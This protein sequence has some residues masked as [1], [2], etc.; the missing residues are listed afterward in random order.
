MRL[1]LGCGRDYRE[2]WVNV[3]GNRTVKLDCLCEFADGL[4]FATSSVE[5]ML[6][7]NVLEHVPRPALI[8]FLEEMHRV[9]KPGASI[10]IFVPHYSGMWAFKHITHYGFF[11]VGSFDPFKVEAPFNGERYSDIRFH[12]RTEEL[13]FFHHNLQTLPIL[14]K[15]PINGLFNFSTT[16]KQ[17]ME[18]FQVFGFDEIHFVLEVVK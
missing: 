13:L 11:G 3:D 4:P 10:E 15:L 18:R 1:H 6:L 5:A 16:W 2:G 14:S 8:P 17:A 9:G 12:V 7:D